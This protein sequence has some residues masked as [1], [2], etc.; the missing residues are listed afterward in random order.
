MKSFIICLVLAFIFLNGRAYAD[1]AEYDELDY[2]GAFGTGTLKSDTSAVKTI[3]HGSRNLMKVALTFDDGPFKVTGDILDILKAYNVKA[4]FFL[5]GQQ[6]KKFPDLAKRILAEGHEIGNHSYSHKNL[7]KL[8]AAAQHTEIDSGADEIEEVTGYRPILFRPPYNKFNN[9]I[10]D[11]VNS[12]GVTLVEYDDDP[13]D[14]SISSPALVRSR[15]LKELRPGSIIIM[16]DLGK[17]TRPALG[18]IIE[19]LRGEGYELVTVS[20]MIN[21]IANELSD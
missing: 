5:V 1:P 17:G 21:D 3:R 7:L 10:I 20:E 9:A 13:Q 8:T 15:I 4:T 6:V 19:T 12:E 18:T 11:Y 16:H 14:W 2:I